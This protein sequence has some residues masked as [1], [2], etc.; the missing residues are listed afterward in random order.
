MYREK[1]KTNTTMKKDIIRIGRYRLRS[2]SAHCFT[3]F[4]KTY[5]NPYFAMIVTVNQGYPSEQTFIVPMQHGCPHYQYVTAAVIQ[6]F[7]INDPDN[8]LRQC[9][10]F[11]GVRVYLSET[12]TSYRQIVKI[13]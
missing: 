8:I 10:T 1:H 13:K 11:Y 3:W 2:I 12:P 9:P 5:G 7:G 6:R 4:Q